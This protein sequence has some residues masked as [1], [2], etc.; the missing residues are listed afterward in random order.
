M[1][2]LK[3]PRLLGAAVLLATLAV[4]T[5]QAA[6]V[7]LHTSRVS[8]DPND[9]VDWGLWLADFGA[10]TSPLNVTSA[11]GIDVDAIN[12]EGFT[13]LTQDTSYFGDFTSG[14]NILTSSGHVDEFDVQAGPFSSW[15]AFQFD[16]PVFGA[17]INIQA[18]NFGPYEAS[19][20]VFDAFAFSLGL[21]TGNGISGVG[22]GTLLY[23]GV[24]S[25]LAEISTVIVRLTEYTDPDEDG[26]F[27]LGVNQLD[28]VAAEEAPAVP[29]PATLSLLALGGAALAIA[30]RRRTVSKQA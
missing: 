11:G 5:A 10:S 8:L 16:T 1:R 22:D 25:T 24:T 14:E 20:E 6:P 27:G 4:H 30:R 13:R 26:F 9:V 23:L 7:T 21:F 12:P 3:S 18:N 2:S 28:I 17:G 29:E 15:I 19:I